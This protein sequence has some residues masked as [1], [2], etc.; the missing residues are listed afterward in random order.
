ML[1]LISALVFCLISLQIFANETQDIA[2]EKNTALSVLI[3][4]LPNT[5]LREL[6][7]LIDQLAQTNAP[8]LKPIFQS[9]IEGDLYYI[10]SNKQV[11]NAVKE[12]S[13]NYALTDILT[14]A[15]LTAVT[16]SKITKIRTNNSIRGQIRDLLA[17]INFTDPNKKVR[18]EA[19]NQLL[20]NPNDV[21]IKLINKLYA[22]EKDKDVAALMS[23]VLFVEQLKNGTPTE[24]L[25]AVKKLD[26]S[27][28]PTVKNAMT[29]LLTQLEEQNNQDELKQALTQSLGMIEQQTTIFQVLENL[30]FGLSLGCYL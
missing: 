1:R 22:Q 29:D 17:Q 7:P 2:L 23:T 12:S 28:Q 20:T 5:K 10:K 11:V 21:G 4:Q 19:V 25:N 15:P 24:Q 30:F 26:N 9:L 18:L 27:L 3:A 13:K 8:Q 14:N 6:P 16:K